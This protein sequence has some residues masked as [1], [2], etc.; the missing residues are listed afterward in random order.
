MVNEVFHT[1][2]SNVYTYARIMKER[3][4]EK[5]QEKKHPNNKRVIDRILLGRLYRFIHYGNTE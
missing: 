5:A 3:E 1:I 4:R 2:Q